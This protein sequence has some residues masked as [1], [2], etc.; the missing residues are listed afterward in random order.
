MSSKAA[1]DENFG[2]TKAQLKLVL[3]GALYTD[4]PGKVSNMMKQPDASSSFNTPIR[5]A[6]SAWPTRPESR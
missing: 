1:N 4:D 5:S 3:F 6:S 2:L